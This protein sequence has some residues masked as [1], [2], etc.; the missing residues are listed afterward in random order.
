M[1]E[2]LRL[3]SSD[4]GRGKES[5]VHEVVVSGQITGRARPRSSGS[6]LMYCVIK[7]LHDAG[8]RGSGGVASMMMAKITSSSA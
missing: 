4:G 1:G 3:K 7:G 6:Q 5:G 8:T 2:S